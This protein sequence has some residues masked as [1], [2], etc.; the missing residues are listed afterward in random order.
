MEVYLP[1]LVLAVISGIFC[2]LFT[3]YETI[4]DFFIIMHRFKYT[5]VL[6]N[7]LQIAFVYL[8]SVCARFA[9]F[10]GLTEQETFQ[11]YQKVGSNIIHTYLQLFSELGVSDVTSQKTA[12]VGMLVVII[13]NL[14]IAIQL[15]EQ[16]INLIYEE[17]QQL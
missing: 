8:V 10:P 17:Q 9:V 5:K 3:K 14:Q 12:R 15:F 11:T 2:Y 7:I 1:L 6:F 4:G 13:S 16:R